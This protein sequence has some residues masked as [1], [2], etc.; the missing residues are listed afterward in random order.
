[1]LVVEDTST[2]G[3]SALTAVEALREEGADITGVVTLVDRG[4]R[5]AI[6]AHGLPYRTAYT[7]S[8][9]GLS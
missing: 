6:E 1:V 2:T 8:D 7:L 4:G 3:G 5:A 9:L